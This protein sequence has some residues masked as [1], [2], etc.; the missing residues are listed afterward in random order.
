VG[1]AF[2]IQG[3]GRKERS[4]SLGFPNLSHK[5]YLVVSKVIIT[6]ASQPLLLPIGTPSE[7]SLRTIQTGHQWLLSIILAT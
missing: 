4:P 6:T 7:D 3:T 5:M 1:K 2:K